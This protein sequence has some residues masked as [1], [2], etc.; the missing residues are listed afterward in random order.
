MARIAARLSLPNSSRVI[1]THSRTG[2]NPE[3]YRKDRSAADGREDAITT[4]TPAKREHRARALFVFGR[5]FASA[6]SKRR[7]AER[8]LLRSS[9]LPECRPN[10]LSRGVPCHKVSQ[11]H[12]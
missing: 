5:S 1:D 10:A 8:R 6:R 12:E 2:G 11:T 7:S 9:P 4:A 3:L